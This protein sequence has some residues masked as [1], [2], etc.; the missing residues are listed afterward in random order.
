[1]IYKCLNIEMRDYTALGY[2]LF[3]ERMTDNFEL[4]DK[5]VLYAQD[6]LEHDFLVVSN[7]FLTEGSNSYQKL[8]TK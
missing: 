5:V 2:L 1:M 4:D 3:A 8:F 7:L 6:F